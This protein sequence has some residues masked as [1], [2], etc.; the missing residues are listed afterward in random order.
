M[1]FEVKK[2]ENSVVEITVEEEVSSLVKYRKK[3]INQIKKSANVKGFRAGA[4]I[5]DEII[6][7]NYG[8]ARISEACV[9]FA[10]DDLYRRALQESKVVPVEQ[11]VIK[12]II[13]QSPLKFVLAVEVYPEVKI[14]EEDYK[15]IN[16]KKTKVE[17]TD[18]EIDATIEDIKSR[19]TKFEIS[20][21]A[22]YELKIGD[23]AI[24]DTD[25]YDLE[26]NL[27]ENTSMREYKLL[28]G[29]NS[30]VTG[31]EEGLVWAKAWDEK[32]LDIA[33]PDDYHNADFASKKTKFKV[34]IK[35]IEE[36]IKPELTPA[37]IKTIRGKEMSIEEFRETVKAEILDVKESNSRRDDEEKLM[38]ELFKI[39]EVELG[40]SMLKRTIDSVF[41][42][43]KQNI[44]S[45]GARI[46]DYIESLGM[47]EEQYLDVNV[48]PV[49]EKRLKGELILHKI[50]ENEKQIPSDEE[51]NKEIESI[52]SKY[53]SD[54]VKA[55]LKDL[56]KSDSRYYEELRIRMGYAKLIDTFVK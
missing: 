38:D 1:K 52:I 22:H 17:V 40:A 24:I 8:E 31:F 16:I 56:Y 39:S 36:A 32:E 2:I 33:F 10:I 49:A 28:M 6:V 5:P 18:K 25:G 37:F 44:I 7:K 14:S 51:I 48:K 53:E 23:K 12:E 42:E 30:L 29:S 9:E 46:E 34:T 27:L 41:E 3:A 15:K 47:T 55:R 19:L 13:S 45:S 35:N 54:D 20:E 43:I 11:G 50:Q 4:N 21:D 26:G